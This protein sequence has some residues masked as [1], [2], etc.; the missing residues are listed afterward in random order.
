L[1]CEDHPKNILRENALQKSKPKIKD[2]EERPKPWKKTPSGRRALSRAVFQS[3]FVLLNKLNIFGLYRQQ[4]LISLD[5]FCPVL[6]SA[7]TSSMTQVHESVEQYSVNP[8]QQCK[9]SANSTPK[10]LKAVYTIK[11]NNNT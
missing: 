1:V 10:N 6:S 4:F 3:L 5:S 8:M 11:N 2:S 9:T 7:N